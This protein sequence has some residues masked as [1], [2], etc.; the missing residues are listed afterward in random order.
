[1]SFEE[2]N[3]WA[4]LIASVPGIVVY[5]VWMLLAARD[6]PVDRIDWVW[7]MASTILAAIVA[8]IALSIVWGVVQSRRD[9]E[10]DHRSDV[11][12]REIAALG[13]RVG[14]AFLVFGGLAALVLCA[15]QAPWFWIANAVY[16]GFALSAV[17]GSMARLAL[18]RRGLP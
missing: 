6:T 4:G 16:A 14:Q 17:V 9:P 7:P 10:T 12:D 8:A 1:M 11:R 18:Y 13:D 15:V 3:T 5:A 2:R